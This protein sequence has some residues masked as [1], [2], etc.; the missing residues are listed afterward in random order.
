MTKQSHHREGETSKIRMLKNNP[1]KS[2]F[3]ANCLSYSDEVT[4]TYINWCVAFRLSELFQT[5][6]H[7]PELEKELYNS[8]SYVL[9]NVDSVDLKNVYMCGL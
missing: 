1:L 4:T 6:K 7:L 8:S 2:Y 9:Y 5:I 3:C